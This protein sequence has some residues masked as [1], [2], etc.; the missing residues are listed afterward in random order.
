M[1]NI[2]MWS[3]ERITIMVNGLNP[4]VSVFLSSVIVQVRVVFRETVVDDYVSTP[5]VESSSESSEESLSD[6]DIYA[7][8]HGFDWLV[9][10]KKVITLDKQITII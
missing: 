3:C 10:S 4:G 1:H 8:G 9:L 2:I 7:S 6:D 5:W